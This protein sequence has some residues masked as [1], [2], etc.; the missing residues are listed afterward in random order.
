MHLMT[1]FTTVRCIPAGTEDIL[2][3]QRPPITLDG[4]R[5][6]FLET[7]KRGEDDDFSSPV[8]FDSC[9][10]SKPSTIVLRLYEAYGGHGEVNLYIHRHIG[11]V[12]AYSTN[13]LEDSPDD[14][15]VAITRVSE[16]ADTERGGAAV[17]R[18]KFRGFEVKTIK[19][20]LGTPQP[21]EAKKQ[22]SVLD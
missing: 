15:E 2:S 18:L 8:S 5:N 14:A 6:V 12:K 10:S 21:G 19:L 7:V 3:V 13:L 20:V 17:I 16:G 1:S 9:S 22:R 11:V 4:T